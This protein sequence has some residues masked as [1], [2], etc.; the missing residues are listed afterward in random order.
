MVGCK[1][2]D[3]ANKLFSPE[4]AKSTSLVKDFNRGVQSEG[5]E[6]GTESFIYRRLIVDED[7]YKVHRH[8]V[9]ELLML[10]VSNV[11]MITLS[12]VN[13]DDFDKITEQL[14]ENST[15]WTF[16]IILF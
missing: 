6:L 1:F 10:F 14:L 15:S 2:W 12:F 13:T 7:V 5:E 8:R 9:T 16:F 3:M 11:S 4:L